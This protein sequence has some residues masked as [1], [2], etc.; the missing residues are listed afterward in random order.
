MADSHGEK[1]QSNGAEI[2]RNPEVINFTGNL[3]ASVS[4]DQATL[5]VTTKNNPTTTATA[6]AA[7]TGTVSLDP[8]LARV[9]TVTPTGNI[10]LNAASAPAGAMV[11]LVVTTSGT[12]SFTTTFSTKFKST[13]TL[14]S[15]TVSAKV[16]TITFIGDGTNLNEVSRTAAM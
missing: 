10:T 13:A 3:S 1:Y 7:T 2:V 15:G 9:F 11:T 14:A 16:F 5:S 4:A 8:T 12:S 6:L